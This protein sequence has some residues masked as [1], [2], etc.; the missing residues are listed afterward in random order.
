MLARHAELQLE[1]L[2][3]SLAI[4]LSL[5]ALLWVNVQVALAIALATLTVQGVVTDVRWW[6]SRHHLDTFETLPDDPSH[7]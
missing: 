5:V 2:F 4:L 3:L 6:F 7:V 1:A